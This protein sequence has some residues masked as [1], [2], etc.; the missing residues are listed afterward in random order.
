MRRPIPILLLCAVLAGCSAS[1]QGEAS[2]DSSA[3]ATSATTTETTAPPPATT[4]PAP[5]PT[6]TPTHKRILHTPRPTPAP[7]PTTPKPTPTPTPTYSVPAGRVVVLDPGHNGGNASHPEI[8]NQLVPAG[9]GTTKPCNTT[10]TATNAGYSEHAFNWAVALQVRQLLEQKDI[11]VVMTRPDDTGVGPCVDKR[12]GI[13]NSAHA[14]AVVSIHGDG[15]TYGHGFH[16]MRAVHDL[17]TAS[18]DEA[19][20]RLAVDVHSAMLAGSGMTTATYAG[21]N[22][23]DQRSDLAGLNLSSRP[24]IMIECGNMRDAGDAARMSSVDGQDHIA[25]AIASGIEEFLN[26]H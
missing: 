2:D 9:D 18:A 23:Y 20:A 19:S 8:I 4:T 25:A 5:A 12:A 6:K 26:G 7:Q 17:G 3:T 24:T 15:A 10:G 21:S 16:I 13:G 1:A 22:G 11:T 14:T